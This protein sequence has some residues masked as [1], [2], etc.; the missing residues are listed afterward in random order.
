MEYRYLGNSGLKVSALSFGAWVTFSDQVGEDVA[1]KCMKEA[2]EAGVNFFDNAEVYANG[3]AE[4]MMGNILKKTGWKRSDLIISTKLFWGGSGPND[5][6]LSRKHILEGTDAALKRLQLSYVDL[7]FCHRPDFH[8]PVEETV[9]AMNHVINQGKALYWGTSEWQTER[10]LEAYDIARR[11]KL[12]P[13]L[14]EQPEYN[15]FRREK[16]EKEFLPLYEKFKLGTT[17][18]SPLASGVLTGKYNNGMPDSTRLSLQSYEWLKNNVFN[19]EGQKRIEKVKKLEP[20]AKELGLT[21]AEMGLAWCL[22][23]PNVSTVITGASKPEQVKQN[24]KALDAVPKL[25][26][27]VMKKIEEIIQTKPKLEYDWRG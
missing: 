12:I 16:I 26:D 7:I 14:M 10:I 4:I 24:M 20:F 9:R 22:K 18:W 19:E 23:N 11:E 15:M 13:P 5:T 3:E 27:D 1:Y 17:I 6:G 8:T 2:Y 21:L 25:T